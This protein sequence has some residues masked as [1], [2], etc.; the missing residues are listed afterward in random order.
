MISP[1]PPA[2]L[3]GATGADRV[4]EI[5]RLRTV[6]QDAVSWL[7]E[8]GEPV[9]VLTAGAQCVVAE[10]TALSAAAY[11]LDYRTHLGRPGSPAA[12][13]APRVPGL[14]VAGYLLDGHPATGVQVADVATAHR[15]VAELDPAAVLV[16]GGGSA[17]RRDGAPGHVDPRAVPYDDALAAQIGSADLAALSHTDLPLGDELLCDL[18]RP[19]A[20]AARLAARWGPV[21]GRL[22][23]YCAPYGVAN[24]VGRW[25]S[26]A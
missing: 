13:L 10:G 12:R 22:D 6:L 19:L 16:C 11:G 15:Q 18:A 1:C 14:L 24:L 8:P 26:G 23:A 17:R 5:E 2:L 21:H 25:W 3:P 9:L 4:P 20:V 7:L